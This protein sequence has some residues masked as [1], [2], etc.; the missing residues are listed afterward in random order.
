MDRKSADES[1][2]GLFHDELKRGAGCGEAVGF[3]FT[4]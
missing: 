1:G 4:L 3:S 2:R